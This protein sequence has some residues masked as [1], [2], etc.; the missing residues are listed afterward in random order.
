MTMLSKIIVYVTDLVLVAVGV[1]VRDVLGDVDVLTDHS[2]P[3]ALLGG[4]I[5]CNIY[6]VSVVVMPTPHSYLKHNT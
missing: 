1:P 2:A 3:K 6:S 4:E 5:V